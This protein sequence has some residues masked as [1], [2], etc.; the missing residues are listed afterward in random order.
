MHRFHHFNRKNKS[1]LFLRSGEMS[2]IKHNV[3]NC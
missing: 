1:S 3:Q 2:T